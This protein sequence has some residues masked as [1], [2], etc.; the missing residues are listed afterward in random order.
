MNGLNQME[1]AGI[2]ILLFWDFSKDSVFYLN[3]SNTGIMQ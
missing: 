1:P 2:S 3:N